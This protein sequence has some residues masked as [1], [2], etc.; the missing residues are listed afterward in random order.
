MKHKEKRMKNKEKRVI[1]ME[2]TVRRSKIYLIQERR[3]RMEK[4]QYLKKYWLIIFQN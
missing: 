4:R 3:E 2:Y 1:G